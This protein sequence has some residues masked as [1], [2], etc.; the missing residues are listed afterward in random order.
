MCKQNRERQG[1]KGETR[2]RTRTKNGFGRMWVKLEERWRLLRHV[3]GLKRGGNGGKLRAKRGE[4]FTRRADRS[5]WIIAKQITDRQTKKKT[6]GRSQAMKGVPWRGILQQN[7]KKT[8]RG[9]QSAH[10]ISGDV[11]TR[12]RVKE[13]ALS[14][15]K[16]DEGKGGFHAAT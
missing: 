9:N 12:K 10:K 8:G 15:Q 4:G 16:G 14:R 7:S 6:S 11:R 3:G 2:R 13:T 5:E 1:V